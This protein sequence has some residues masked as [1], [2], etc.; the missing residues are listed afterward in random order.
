[1]KIQINAS[2]RLTAAKADLNFA[3][4]YIQ[5]VAGIKVNRPSRYENNYVEF[6]L[7]KKRF[8]EAKY[9][10]SKAFGAP[11]NIDPGNTRTVYLAWKDP[12]GGSIILYMSSDMQYSIGL[13]NDPNAVGQ[14][15][16][17]KLRAKDDNGD[18]ERLDQLV[19]QIKMFEEDVKEIEE[20][21]DD[22]TVERRHL[23][24]LRDE[25]RRLKEKMGISHA[26][27]RSPH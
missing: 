15:A 22:A 20:D 18:K 25:Q 2:A 12:K 16:S 3:V 5:S 4:R 6:K 9:Q 21:G 26:S 8:W 24:S 27:R 23:E 1:M 7:D 14:H 10:L 11:K 13:D 19:K 17:T